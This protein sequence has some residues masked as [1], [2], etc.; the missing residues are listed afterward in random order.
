[1]LNP[2]VLAD[3]YWPNS[4]PWF[5]LELLNPVSGSMCGATLYKIAKF[6]PTSENLRAS[7]GEFLKNFWGTLYPNVTALS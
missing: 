5:P 6:L 3:G 7:T 2:I 1:M 4:W